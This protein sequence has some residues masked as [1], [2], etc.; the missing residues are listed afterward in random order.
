MQSCV[1]EHTVDEANR[2]ESLGLD[3]FGI[4]F[5]GRKLANLLLRKLFYSVKWGFRV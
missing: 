4:G 1:R 5:L 2:K 3:F